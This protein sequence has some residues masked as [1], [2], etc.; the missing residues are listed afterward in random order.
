MKLT[1]ERWVIVAV[2][3]CLALAVA[4]LPADGSRSFERWILE[5]SWTRADAWQMRFEGRADHLGAVI[6]SY[7]AAR[8]LAEAR[9]FFGSTSG[10]VGD[11]EVRFS[12]DVPAAFRAEFMRALD[13]E[14]GRRPGWTGRGKVGVL[15]RIDTVTRVNGQAIPRLETKTRETFSRVIAPSAET[16][17]RCVAVVQLPSGNPWAGIVNGKAA[18][19]VH[20]LLD[21]CGYYDA[22][23]SPGAAIGRELAD[24][25]YFFARGYARV[26]AP[27]D[28]LRRPTSFSLQSYSNDTREVRCLAGDDS[29]CLDELRGTPDASWWRWQGTTAMPAGIS[30]YQSVNREPRFPNSLNRMALEMGPDRFERVW[31]SEGSLEA[32]YRAEVGETLA[33]FERREDVHEDGAYR[34]GPWTSAGT[35][36]LTL[37][38]IGGLMGVS[39]RFGRRPGVV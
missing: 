6:H 3:G 10:R 18:G 19:P 15:V 34:E 14:R 8:D 2:M 38:W 39:L 21:A 12:S 29:S 17:G 11:P 30:S 7:V 5:R 26:T 16:G 1:F 35:G 24:D 28:T 36:L 23:G 33:G 32:A 20:P 22:F 37:G 31:R 27:V 4:I 25:R 9:E 13:D